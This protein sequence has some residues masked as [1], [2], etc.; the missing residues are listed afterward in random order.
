MRTWITRSFLATSGVL[1]SGCLATLPNVDATRAADQPDAVSAYRAAADSEA[2]V[3]DEALR[4]LKDDQAGAP[5]GTNATIEARVRFIR[6]AQSWDVRTLKESRLA[7]PA[8]AVAARHKAASEALKAFARHV[9]KRPD[10]GVTK[11]FVT[12]PSAADRAWMAAQLRAAGAR[13]V[14]EDYQPY[15][16]VGFTSPALRTTR[17]VN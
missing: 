13:D 5:K 9:A 14:G 3:F 12:A 16:A 8:D 1:L 6:G 4:R 17:Q 2:K 10:V 15:T 7:I 11:L